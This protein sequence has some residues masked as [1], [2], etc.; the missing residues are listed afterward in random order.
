MG[1]QDAGYSCKMSIQ[2]VSISDLLKTAASNLVE[3]H[4]PHQSQLPYINAQHHNFVNPSRA[5]LCANVE[6][7]SKPDLF[8]VH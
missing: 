4:L 2:M 7:G 6:A 8:K 5:K 3:S 1:S